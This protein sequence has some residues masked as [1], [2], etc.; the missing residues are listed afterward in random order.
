M[1]S[2]QSPRRSPARSAKIAVAGLSA[3]ALMAIV[4][5]FAAAAHEHPQ[6]PTA[7]VA[8]APAVGT[9]QVWVPTPVAAAPVPAPV[10]ARAPS[11]VTNGTT[12]NGT[13]TNGTSRGS[14][15]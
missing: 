11:T 9:G 4:T 2:R 14:G 10:P 3:S 12:S 7:G 13:A 5:G 1:T 8:D 15:G 6:V